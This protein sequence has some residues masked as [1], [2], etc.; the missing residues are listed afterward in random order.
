MKSQNLGKDKPTPGGGGDAFWHRWNTSIHPNRKMWFDL[1]FWTP[2]QL[3]D[4]T[5]PTLKT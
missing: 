4:G 3:R 2:I 1:C 5:Q